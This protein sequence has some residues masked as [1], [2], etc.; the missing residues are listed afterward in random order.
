MN[1]TYRRKNKKE[2]DYYDVEQRKQEKLREISRRIQYHMVS[3][4]SILISTYFLLSCRH[5]QSA[6]R[7]LRPCEKLRY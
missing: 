5:I 3:Q 4:K 1:S 2:M 7:I 6:F